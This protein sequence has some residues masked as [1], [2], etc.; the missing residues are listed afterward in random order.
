M[1]IELYL[2]FKTY[3]NLV[4]RK[5]V[6]YIHNSYKM[7]LKYH[8]IILENY[9]YLR[10]NKHTKGIIE[11]WNRLTFKQISRKLQKIQVK[12][13]EA[14]LV[15]SNVLTGDDFAHLSDL[16]GENLVHL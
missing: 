5:P 4:E 16:L 12:R 13:W 9:E 7:D 14:K 8:T 1:V 11:L 6:P 2:V 3:D 10:R 15:R